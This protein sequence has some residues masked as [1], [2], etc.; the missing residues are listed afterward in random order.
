MHI[1]FYENKSDLDLTQKLTSVSMVCITIDIG[2][3]G[4][5]ELFSRENKRIN[6]RN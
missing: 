6:I 1:K 3:G 4:V 2:F 5:S